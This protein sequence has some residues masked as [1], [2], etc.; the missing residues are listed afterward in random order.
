MKINLSI[1]NYGFEEIIKTIEYF[2]IDKDP[3]KLNKSLRNVC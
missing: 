3:E 1:S 2:V